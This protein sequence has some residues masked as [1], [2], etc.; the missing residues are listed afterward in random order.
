MIQLFP[1]KGVSN[2][3]AVG[4]CCELVFNIYQMLALHT[5]NISNLLEI[6]QWM[7][8]FWMVDAGGY[9]TLRHDNLLG[10]FSHTWIALSL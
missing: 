7:R 6:N 3:V 8:V 1:P 10:V 4:D 9:A 5:I 2:S